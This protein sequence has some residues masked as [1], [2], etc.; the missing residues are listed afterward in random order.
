MRSFIPVRI[1]QFDRLLSQDMQS[2][3]GSG[4]RTQDGKVSG[5]VERRDEQ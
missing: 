4:T 1:H 2:C 5:R 3:I